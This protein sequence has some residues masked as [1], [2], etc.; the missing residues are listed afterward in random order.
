M[1]TLIISLDLAPCSSVV[2]VS[3]TLCDM[4]RHSTQTLRQPASLEGILAPI[5]DSTTT[6]YAAEAQYQSQQTPVN[7]PCKSQ[8]S[9]T[10]PKPKGTPTT[11][12]SGVEAANGTPNSHKSRTAARDERRLVSNLTSAQLQRK[13]ANDR[14]LQR[15]YRARIRYT[16]S[17]L[18]EELQQLRGS[19]AKDNESSR[20]LHQRI[21]ALEKEVQHERRLRTNDGKTIR[22]LRQRIQ[23]L[24]KELRGEKQLRVN[25]S[26]AIRELHHGNQVLEEELKYQKQLRINDSE[27]IRQP[28]YE[29]Q[30]YEPDVGSLVW[31]LDTLYSSPSVK[32]LFIPVEAKRSGVVAYLVVA[33][34]D[35][36]ASRKLPTG[37]TKAR[38]RKAKK[39][40]SGHYSDTLRLF[41]PPTSAAPVAGCGVRVEGM[42][43]ATLLGLA[44]TMAASRTSALTGWKG[45]PRVKL[46][47][48]LDATQ[49]P[50]SPFSSELAGLD[51]LR[52]APRSRVHIHRLYFGALRNARA[53]QS[54]FVIRTPRQCELVLAAVCDGPPKGAGGLA[55]RFY[56]R[57]TWQPK[58]CSF[59]I[60]P[61]TPYLS[62]L[63]MEP[64]TAWTALTYHDESDPTAGDEQVTLD[65]YRMEL[66]DLGEEPEDGGTYSCLAP[67]CRKA[68]R[69]PDVL[70]FHSKRCKK[71]T[72]SP[73]A[74]ARIVPSIP[75]FAI[76]RTSWSD[77]TQNAPAGNHSTDGRQSN[78]RQVSAS[79]TLYLNIEATPES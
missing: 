42:T 68:F 26:D 62:T 44:V 39:A 8:P 67:G 7:I 10:V 57:I 63:S 21:I 28:R 19:Q 49:D 31:R 41:M 22:Q 6:V 56:S 79:F 72:A 52:R 20:E 29:Y 3:S 38:A 51:P 55:G 74:V 12:R 15:E 53:M 40:C 78:K 73:D 25:D 35:L 61:F 77:V 48:N 27:T 64:P 54:L 2:D 47:A 16:I 58:D 59:R 46:R 65:I 36:E 24:E 30:L 69:E 17:S 34:V 14:R 33:V 32:S 45:R 75:Y 23:A 50:K 70:E 66:L 18:E 5:N 4:R 76:E 1:A 60:S 71:L 9:S 37:F 43:R 11:K 13:R